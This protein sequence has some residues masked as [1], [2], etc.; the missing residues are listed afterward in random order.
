MKRIDIPA[1][2]IYEVDAQ[3]FDYEFEC[4]A[5]TGEL[6]KPG[7]AAYMVVRKRDRKPFRVALYAPQDSFARNVYYLQEW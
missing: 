1:T 5:Q 2:T 4:L 7:E 3:E 6:K